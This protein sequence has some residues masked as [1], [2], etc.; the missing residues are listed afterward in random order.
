MSTSHCIRQIIILRNWVARVPRVAFFAPLPTCVLHVPMAAENEDR[1]NFHFFHQK[2]LRQNL[3]SSTAV[4]YR[5]MP[6]LSDP[7]R[8]IHF[9]SISREV[10]R[11]RFIPG[12]KIVL[13]R[14]HLRATPGRQQS[15]T[16]FEK[17]ARQHYATAQAQDRRKP[18]EPDVHTSSSP[19]RP[20]PAPVNLRKFYH[21]LSRRTVQSFSS[22][23]V[24][25]LRLLFS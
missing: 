9:S 22:V 21:Q 10:P 8:C 1:R 12:N 25:F 18:A 20:Q 6:L 15:S 7:E 24:A 3:L 16:S 14:L 4:V 17:T 19:C 2:C 13:L 23:S 11:L 5:Q